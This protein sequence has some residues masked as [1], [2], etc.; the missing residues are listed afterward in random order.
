[1]EEAA[2]ASR[3]PTASL[4]ALTQKG[5]S[6]HARRRPPLDP[7]QTRTRYVWPLH[8][9]RRAATRRT[10]RSL[11]KAYRALRAHPKAQTM[12]RAEQEE[13][14]RPVCR[15]PKAQAS[16]KSSG[17]LWRESRARCL[18]VTIGDHALCASSR[19]PD[20]TAHRMRCIQRLTT[21]V[22]VATIARAIKD[23][24]RRR[25]ATRPHGTPPLTRTRRARLVRR[26]RRAALIRAHQRRLRS[27]A[28]S[29]LQ[30][31]AQG[32]SPPRARAF[33]ARSLT[34]HALRRRARSSVR[35]RAPQ[36][37]RGGIA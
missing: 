35:S 3:D 18:A 9:T 29:Q 28:Y 34:A 27:T 15:R 36:S 32:V 24:T 13:P 4:M 37:P 20:S 5:L 23:L 31:S 11:R 12:E 6:L 19:R 8:S 1:M 22:P 16:Q 17:I 33:Q 30:G 10:V 7:K 25:R 26:R 21:S 14:Y 2:R